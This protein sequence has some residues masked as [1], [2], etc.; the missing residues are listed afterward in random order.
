[1]NDE[2][3]QGVINDA[4]CTCG[5][6]TSKDASKI[7]CVASRCPCFKHSRPCT[8]RCQ[9]HNCKNHYN[10][11]LNGGQQNRDKESIVG[12]GCVAAHTN[13]KWTNQVSSRAETENESQS[14][15]VLHEVLDAQS[16]VC[17][18]TVATLFEHVLTQL[19][20]SHEE[21]GSENSFLHIRENEGK[22]LWNQ[23]KWALESFRN[24]LFDRMPR[25]AYD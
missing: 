6:N 2:L 10:K 25:C 20:Q 22:S 12:G 18:S 16:W 7:S 19:H 24:S 5:K 13:P 14:V 23:K 21:S 17:A 15:H 3:S 1:M 4:T 9:C 8:R 11:S